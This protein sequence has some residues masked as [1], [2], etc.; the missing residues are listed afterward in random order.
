LWEIT[1]HIEIIAGSFE[2]MDDDKNAV[3]V[4]SLKSDVPD[5]K[6]KQ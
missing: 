3:F 2:K 4:Y 5:T 1:Y 6:R